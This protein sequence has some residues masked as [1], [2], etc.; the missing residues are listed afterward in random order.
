MRAFL[1]NTFI[2]LGHTFVQVDL[3]SEQALSKLLELR[4]SPS[5]SML[6][7]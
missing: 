5:L 6:D 7:C 3:Q 2:I 1:K 4:L